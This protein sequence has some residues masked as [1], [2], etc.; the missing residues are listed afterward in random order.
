[1]A[2]SNASIRMD[3]RE[4]A[5]RR[6]WQLEQQL[7]GDEAAAAAPT[8]D[9]STEVS[10]AVPTTITSGLD[11]LIKQRQDADGLRDSVV[12]QLTAQ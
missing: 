3:R 4:A 2:R 12:T 10:P 6:P 9:Q 5:D 11:L 7:I 1:M 8:G